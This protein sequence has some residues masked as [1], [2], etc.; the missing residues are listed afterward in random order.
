MDL[1]QQF[2]AHWQKRAL[3]PGDKTILLAV[4]GGVDSMVMAELFLKSGISFAVA[5]CNFQLRGEEADKDQQLVEDF[6]KKNNIPFH[7]ARFDTKQRSEEWKKGIQETARILRYE[8]L[9]SIRAEHNYAVIATAHHA[10]DNAETLLINLFKGTGI[11][12][13]HGIQEKN[14]NIIRPLLFAGKAEI[15]EYAKQN[16][17]AYRED[18]SNSSDDYL[19]NAVRRH[20]IPTAEEWFPGAVQHVNDS[21]NRFA[22]AEVL[23]MKAVEHERKKLI[24]PRG[25]D[26]YIAV[27]KLI[28]R[29]PLETICYELFKPFGCTSQQVS[30]VISL[31]SS[32]PGKFVSTGTH[33]IIRDRDFLIITADKAAAA[34]FILIEGFPCTIE[35]EHGKFHFSI[36][37]APK[38]I[39]SANTIACLDADKLSLPLTLRKWKQGDYFYPLG[40]GMKKKKLSKLFIDQKVPLHEKE[41]IWVLECQKRI[42]WVSGMRL[43][44]RFKLRPVTEKMV[45]VEFTAG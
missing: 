7:V 41:R 15:A 9:D 31:L 21:I 18:A 17:I 45:K 34:D 3:I 30:Q 6:T 8:R 16:G 1:L 5:H 20:L 36:E 27:R 25:Q 39:P 11:A 10:N 14:G 29:V 24:E 22:Q 13:L 37:K 19:R 38:A 2:R 4:S 23:Y 44:E 26:H 32:E 33:R 42:A 40:M 43:D 12:G 35:T 28:K